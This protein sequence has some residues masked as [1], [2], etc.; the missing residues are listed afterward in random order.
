MYINMP[1]QICSLQRNSPVPLK[2]ESAAFPNMAV[3]YNNQKKQHLEN[4]GVI[5]LPE[6]V[7]HTQHRH[8]Q[9]VTQ[10]THGAVPLL[11]RQP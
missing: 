7:Q 11:S 5:K 9:P 2:T 4:P 6:L 3:V 8:S 1:Y 10:T